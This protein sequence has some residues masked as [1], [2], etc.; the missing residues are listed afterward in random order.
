MPL[1]EKKSKKLQVL[2]ES[3]AKLAREKRPV[4]KKLFPKG[5]RRRKLA[6][7]KAAAKTMI[8]AAKERARE[9]QSTDSNQ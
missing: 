6:L 9:R 5:E 3:Q 8:E 7:S 4:R 1:L 2:A